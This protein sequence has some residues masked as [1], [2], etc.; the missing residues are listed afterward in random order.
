MV[1]EFEQAMGGVGLISI[2][3]CFYPDLYRGPWRGASNHCLSARGFSEQKRST[4]GLNDQVFGCQSSYT[5][6]F[7]WD[8]GTD[9]FIVL[10]GCFWPRLCKN[11]GIDLAVI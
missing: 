7:G 8:K 9:L 11:A 4:A 5:N 6:S 3:P 2:R 1:S 10:R